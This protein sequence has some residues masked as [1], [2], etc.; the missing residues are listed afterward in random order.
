[1][2]LVEINWT[3]SNKVLKQFG[4]I[5]LVATA[6][7]AV[8]LHFNKGIEWKWCLV[9][10]I[11]GLF[12]VLICRFLPRMGRLIFVGM[13]LITAPIGIILGF[14]VLALFYYLILTPVGLVFRLAG[15]DALCRPFPAKGQNGWI[16]RKSRPEIRHYFRQF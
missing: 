11:S 4:W 16:K 13:S 1:M 14:L 15:R 3:P 6:I 5:S 9:L 2:S 12:I 8:V 10:P 7:L